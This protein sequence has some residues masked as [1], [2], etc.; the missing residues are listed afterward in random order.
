MKLIRWFHRTLSSFCDLQLCYLLSVDKLSGWN[1]SR[2]KL[3]CTDVAL[4]G[5]GEAAENGFPSKFRALAWWFSHDDDCCCLQKGR[6][7]LCRSPPLRSSTISLTLLIR[8]IYLF[9]YWFCI[10]LAPLVILICSYRSPWFILDTCLWCGQNEQDPQ[11]K[12]CWT[13][14]CTNTRECE[15]SS[16]FY[17]FMYAWIFPKDYFV[18]SPC[19][20]EYAVIGRLWE[21]FSHI[22]LPPFTRPRRLWFEGSFGIP[23]LLQLVSR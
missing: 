15:Y 7:E 20:F 21:I 11:R 13:I 12:V 10:S 23:L 9:K 6:L 16:I 22:K 19:G 18:I 17:L 2:W 5:H 8:I 14:R 4:V 1:C 3:N